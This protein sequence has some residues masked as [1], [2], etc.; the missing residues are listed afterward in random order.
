[1]GLKYYHFDPMF[2]SFA[3]AV[4]F[5]FAPAYYF[6]SDRKYYLQ[7]ELF[8][9]YYWFDDK[10]LYYRDENSAYSYN[11]I[12]SERANVFGIKLLAGINV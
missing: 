5:S 6:S 8:Y 2:N 12:R 3:H 4:Y 7:A 1:M 9:R 10:Q 11:S